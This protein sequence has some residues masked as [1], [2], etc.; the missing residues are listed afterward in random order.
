MRLRTWALSTSPGGARSAANS[1]FLDLL[2]RRGSLV[3]TPGTT[4][5]CNQTTEQGMPCISL[6]FHLPRECQSSGVMSIPV[7][8]PNACLRTNKYQTTYIFYALIEE[9]IGWLAGVG[10]KHTL[11]RLYLENHGQPLARL[12]SSSWQRLHSGFVS[13][14]TSLRYSHHRLPGLGQMSG[15]FGVIEVAQARTSSGDI[16]GD[17]IVTLTLAN[18]RQMSLSLPRNVAQLPQ[19]CILDWLEVQNEF[20]SRA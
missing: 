3:V 17:Y 10:P 12:Y 13:F 1:Q 6:H 16:S 9:V 18:R 11:V 2:L 15:S 19:D 8:V 4:V 7:L 20:S 14:I 5:T